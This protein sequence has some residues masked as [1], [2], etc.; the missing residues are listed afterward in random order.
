MSSSAEVAALGDLDRVDF[1]DEVGDRDVGGGELFAVAAVALDPVDRGVVALD[2]DE[3]AAAPADGVERVV[4]DLAAGD[5]GDLGIEEVGERANEA[6]LG[7]PALSEEDDV[8]SGEDGVF[9]VGDDGIF[10]ADDPREVL[11][12]LLDSSDQ[13]RAHLLLD[14]LRG[15]SGAAQLPE[16]LRNLIGHY[17]SSPGSG[18]SG[19]AA[20]PGS[21]AGQEAGDFV[22]SE[23]RSVGAAPA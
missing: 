9:E 10:V 19:Y 14:G 11:L 7:L 15:V 1:A 13:V 3:V 23:L 5:D 22:P 16:R 18:G 8:L 12:V 17:S 4:V 20:A 2:V 21:S 6:R